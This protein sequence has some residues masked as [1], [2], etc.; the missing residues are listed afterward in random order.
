MGLC[1]PR[2][3][4][5]KTSEPSVGQLANKANITKQGV[6][7]SVLILYALVPAWVIIKL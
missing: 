4:E 2:I 3:E 6:K 1:R 5:K 7:T